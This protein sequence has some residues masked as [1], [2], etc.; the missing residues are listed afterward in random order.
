MIPSSLPERSRPRHPGV[1]LVG[2]VTPKQLFVVEGSRIYDLDE[3]TYGDLEAALDAQAPSEVDRLLREWQLLDG[4]GSTKVSAG[5]PRTRALSLAVAQR[6]NMGC[7]YCYAQQGDFGSAPMAM[8]EATARAAV[9]LLLKDA[10]PGDCVNLAFLGGEP[11]SARAVLQATTRYAEER[12]KALGARVTFSMTTNGT[13]LTEEDADFFEAHAF[14]ITV[15]LDG[16]REKHNQLRVFKDGRPTFDVVV[17]KTEPLRRRQ[18]A[19]QVS[20]RV[21]VTPRNLG[22]RTTLDELLGLGFHSVGFSPLL[23]SPSGSD[24]MTGEALAQMLGE[25]IEC[26]EEFER[27]LSAGERY[28]FSN[29]ATA[30]RELHRGSHR[31]YPCGA[32]AGYLGVSADGQLAAC[33]RFVGDDEG[34][35]GSLEAGVD[36]ERQ[37][38]WLASRHVHRQEPCGSCWARYLCG[39][40]CHHEVL[41][42]GRTACDYI[43]GWLHY[44][45]GAYARLSSSVPGWFGPG[46]A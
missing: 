12:A 33:H 29:L 36:V 46:L 40:G 37:A 32:G 22:L 17:R 2:D 39:G 4:D 43:R 23:R 21:T 34:R 15:S 41:Q 14:A 8:P 1:H 24:E 10:A 9:D 44:C 11:L 30:L 26:G 45:L 19:M 38:A 28:A 13:L 6:C 35:M 7:T 16:T 31:S 3:G 20:A 25:M 5:L 18:R 42:R 27:R